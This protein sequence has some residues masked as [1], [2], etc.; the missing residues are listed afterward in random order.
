MSISV[1]H[2]NASTVVLHTSMRVSSSLLAASLTGCLAS[3]S[4]STTAG[5]RALK[6]SLKCSPESTAAEASACKPPCD[7]R[8]LL[9]FKRSRQTSTSDVTSDGDSVFLEASRSWWRRSTPAIRSLVSFARASSS[10]SS[11]A[12]AVGAVRGFRRDRSRRR[13]IGSAG[14][15]RVRKGEVWER[16]REGIKIMFVM[17]LENKSKYFDKV[18]ICY[19]FS[20]ILVS[21]LS[22]LFLINKIELKIWIIINKHFSSNYHSFCV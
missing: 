13:S 22:F 19:L 9:S 7:T 17:K 21:S 10:A 14:S 11:I 4:L 6:C 16:E 15:S 5:T 1:Q 3:P 12:A 2:A 20:E 8:K 18:R